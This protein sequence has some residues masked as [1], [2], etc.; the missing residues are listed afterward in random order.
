MKVVTD[1]PVVWLLLKQIPIITYPYRS[2][3]PLEGILWASSFPY[4]TDRYSLLFLRCYI[5]YL[6]YILVNEQYNETNVSRNI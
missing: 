3:K 5:E 2:Q 1:D 6:K 4:R